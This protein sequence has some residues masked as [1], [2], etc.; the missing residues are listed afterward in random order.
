[1]KNGNT[2]SNRSSSKSAP[3]QSNTSGGAGRAVS[4]KGSKSTRG[5]SRTK[6]PADLRK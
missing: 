4:D 2:L 3:G 5:N 6:L 1:M